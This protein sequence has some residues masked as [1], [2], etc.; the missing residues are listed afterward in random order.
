MRS[1]LVVFKVL[2]V[3]CNVP[4]SE[5]MNGWMGLKLFRV[6]KGRVDK[7]ENNRLCHGCGWI[8]QPWYLVGQGIVRRQ[9]QSRF[10][11]QRSGRDG[12]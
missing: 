4:G 11:E 1:I 5:L 9:I 12:G 10:T 2:L 6:K 8:L 7:V 3:K